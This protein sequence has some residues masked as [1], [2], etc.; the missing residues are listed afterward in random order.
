MTNKKDEAIFLP[1][2]MWRQQVTHKQ[3]RQ[4]LS[5]YDEAKYR[6]MFESTAIGIALSRLDGTLVETN[7]TYREIIGYTSE[8]LQNLNF[9][10]YT[11]PDDIAVYLAL[12]Q[13]V[14]AQKRD[15]F[16][17]EERYIHKQG[18][19]IWVHLNFSAIRSQGGSILFIIAMVQDITKQKQ[20][21]ERW[22]LLEKAVETAQAANQAKSK[23]ISSMSH[24]LRTPLNSILGFAQMLARD[25]S[26]NS[27]QQEYLRI[28]NHSGE[29]LLNLI[30]DILSIS[31]IE[32]GQ[33]TLQITEFDLYGLLDSL[34]EVFQ[35]KANSNNLELEFE[36]DPTVTQFIR[37]DQHKLRQILTNLLSNALKYTESGSV[38]LRVQS[39]QPQ[40]LTKAIIASGATDQ[41]L[42]I[43]FT[44]TDTGAGIE[45][46]EMVKLFT[47][48][49][50]TATGLESMQG[51]GLG[52]SICREFVNLLD[53]SMVVYSTRDGITSKL[54]H[55]QKI[56]TTT[57]LGEQGTT[58]TV[59]I[60][61][62]LAQPIKQEVV[63][64]S[65]ERRVIGLVNPQ[66]QYRILIA[67]D[68]A[69]NR[70][71]VTKLIQPLGFA[72]REAR[73]GQEA[74]EIWSSWQPH[75]ILMDMFMPVIDGYEATRRIK[76]F[77]QGQGTIIIAL[78]AGNGEEEQ[79]RIF[80]SGCDDFV[81]KP[82]NENVLFAKIGHHL[83]LSYLYEDILDLPSL[84]VM[85]PLWI[86]QLHHAAVCLNNQDVMELIKQIPPSHTG[87]AETLTNLVNNF[88]FDIIADVTKYRS[89]K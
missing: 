15:S 51:T 69:V 21:Q 62:G 72:V 54:S 31:K 28:I 77:S 55:E 17:L 1:E 45:A 80:A 6:A 37:S 13:E 35:I 16:Q 58:F 67:E 89:K 20:L 76:Q 23:F 30:N 44:V 86:A 12:T 43:T 56:T 9:T 78:S 87:L 70:K 26:L 82:I 49:M 60:P 74:L 27:E 32:A 33:V 83:R 68:V 18:Y 48:F 38:T 66:P 22:Q 61:V 3:P 46:E 2:Y 40:E 7:A 84:Q 42:P 39:K 53:G 71:L 75:L 59:T 73:N 19:P 36:L 50:Q 65:K 47:P 14:L 57:A 52:L 25:S 11:H 4:L 63:S 8:E 85:P 81:P 24:E 34:K 79:Q 10:D 29:Y 5:H 64:P 41:L 88:R